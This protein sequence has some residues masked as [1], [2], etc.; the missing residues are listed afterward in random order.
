MCFRSMISCMIFRRAFEMPPKP[1]HNCNKPGC[2]NLT[3]NRLCDDCMKKA[4]KAADSKKEDAFIHSSRWRTLSRLKLALT[5]L[6]ERCGDA[7][8]LVHHKD[9]NQRNNHPSNHE[10]LCRRCHDEEHKED[11]FVKKKVLPCIVG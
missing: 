3:R 6:C 8:T 9:H 2:Y 1:V 11:R 10:S 7:A 4:R 5:P